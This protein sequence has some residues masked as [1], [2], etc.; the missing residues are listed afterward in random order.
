M[1]SELYE[2]QNRC[3]KI[4]AKPELFGYKQ[5]TL[6]QLR[7]EMIQQDLR[8]KTTVGDVVPHPTARFGGSTLLLFFEYSCWAGRKMT[9]WVYRSPAGHAT[10]F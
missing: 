7:S 3:G 4:M 10:N 8:P 6:T 1:Y 2:I 9:N 5:E